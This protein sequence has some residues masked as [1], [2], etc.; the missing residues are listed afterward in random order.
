MTPSTGI[1]LCCSSVYSITLTISFNFL[2]AEVSS[3]LTWTMLGFLV[4]NYTIFAFIFILDRLTVRLTE[5]RVKE[6]ICLLRNIYQWILSPFV[7]LAYSL[8]EFYALHEV[9][10]RGKKVCKQKGCTRLLTE[11]YCK[12]KNVES[13][14][15]PGVDSHERNGNARQR[16]K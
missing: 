8:V 2:F 5:P 3:I 16:L 4:L 14:F 7:L 10:V 12:S 1:I 6:R 15:N 9:M 11:L 13:G